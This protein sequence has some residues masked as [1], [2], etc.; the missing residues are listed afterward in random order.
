M[1]VTLTR[2]QVSRLSSSLSACSSFT[3]SLIDEVYDDDDFDIFNFL[4]ELENL[5][6]EASF[7]RQFITHNFL[8]KSEDP[9]E[10]IQ[11]Q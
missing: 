10:D 3:E 6:G 5:E 9:S 2:S 7:I 11:E 8:T 4:H 1:N